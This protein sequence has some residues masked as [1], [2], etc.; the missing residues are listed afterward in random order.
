MSDG[1]Q[2]KAGIQA[3]QAR[4]HTVGL[5]LHAGNGGEMVIVGFVVGYVYASVC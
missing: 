3:R 5:V 2:R 1:G 4:L